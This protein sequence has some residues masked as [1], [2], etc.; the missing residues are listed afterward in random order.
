MIRGAAS[1]PVLTGMILDC[2]IGRVSY[3][4]LRRKL[5]LRAPFFASRL[6]WERLRSLLKL[7]AFVAA[8]SRVSGSA[9]K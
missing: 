5:A 8:T 1:E 9:V 4:E 7:P 6:V 3:A 2:A